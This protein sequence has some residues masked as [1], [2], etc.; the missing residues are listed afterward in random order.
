MKIILKVLFRSALFT[1]CVRAAQGVLPCYPE[2]LTLVFLAA[3]ISLEN[4]KSV[5]PPEGAAALG[6]G[7][8]ASILFSFVCF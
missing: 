1:Q 4:V 7:V 3:L 8:R 6:I 5:P 2:M